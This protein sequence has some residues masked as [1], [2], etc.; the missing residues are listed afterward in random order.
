METKAN[1]QPEQKVAFWNDPGK[2][3]IIYQILVLGFVLGLG[4]YLFRNTQANLA[5]QSIA[6]GFGFLAQEAAF[7]IGE[8]VIEYS[9]ADTYFRAFVVGT[10]NTIKVAFFGIILAVFLGI[11]MGIARLSSNWIVRQ[12]ATVYVETMRNIPL[13]L[14]LFFW[15][16]LFTEALPHPRKAFNPTTG[17]FLSNRGLY[18]GIPAEHPAFF[19]ASIMAVIAV[20]L[21]IILSSWGKSYQDRTGQ[22]APVFPI[23]I[24]LL[25]GLPLIAW[26]AFGAPTAMNLPELKGFNF[27]G[28]ASMSPEFGALMLGLVLYTGAFMAEVV[29]SGIQ[30]VSHGQTEAAMS[31]GLSQWQTLRKIILPQALRVI[32][33]P[34]TNQMLNLTKNSSLA[35]GIGY[36]DFVSVANTSINQT[37]QAVEGVA[38]IMAMYLFFSLVTS[39]FMNWYNKKIA[40]VER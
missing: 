37:G 19:W 11:V 14:Q 2:R 20:I 36:P 3:A 18:F 12:L 34:M 33:P 23:S 22:V 10:L 17:V 28:G 24:G 8:S 16:S 27:Q 1:S 9:A 32:I 26:L 5:K 21:I 31:V 30:S 39:A 4:F 35:V 6:T 29:R 38:L 25:I 13:L 7:D 15:Y 40:L